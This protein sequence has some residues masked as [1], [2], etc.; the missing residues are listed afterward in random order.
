[1][2]TLRATLVLWL[3]FIPAAN[4]INRHREKQY[5]GARYY[6]AYAYLVFFLVADVL[7]NFSYGSLL[8]MQAPSLKRKTLTARLKHIIKHQTGWRYRL[9]LFICRYLIEPWDSGH[10][11]LAQARHT[12]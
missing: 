9:A 7:F 11:A 2:N 5:R 10:C 4:I 1:M 8:F 12:R 6:A 3:L